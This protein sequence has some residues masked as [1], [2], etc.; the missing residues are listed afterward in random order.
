[1]L[2][3]DIDHAADC[4]DAPDRST[5]PAD[6]LDTFDIF[7]RN[8]VVFPHDA[9]KRWEINTAAI[10]QDLQLVGKASVETARSHGVTSVINLRHLN[11]RRHTQHFG[12]VLGTGAADILGRN[13][14]GRRRHIGQTLALARHRGDFRLGEILQAK[15][16]E[17]VSSQRLVCSGLDGDQHDQMLPRS[18]HGLSNITIKYAINWP[19]GLESEFSSKMPKKTKQTMPKVNSFQFSWI[20]LQATPGGDLWQHLAPCRLR[21]T[22]KNDQFCFQELVQADRKSKGHRPKQNTHAN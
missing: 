11:T 2:A 16:I 18:F 5:L 8:R 19:S 12:Q 1:M 21:S 20:G 14:E 4:I 15:P 6:D 13:H 9:R 3:D 17:R 10:D 22:R 7:Q